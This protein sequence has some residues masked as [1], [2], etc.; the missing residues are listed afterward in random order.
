[1]LRSLKGI[2]ERD[3]E[4]HLLTRGLDELTAGRHACAE[5]GRTPL[6]GEEVHRYPRGLV[7]C[8]LCRAERHG[9]PETSE[10]VAHHEGGCTVRL[11]SRLAA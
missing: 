6:V 11:R 7:V 9:S 10:R 1:M 3:L 2:G 8:T 4:R 5:C